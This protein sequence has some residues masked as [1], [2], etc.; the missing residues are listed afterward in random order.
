MSPKSKAYIQ[1]QQHV[2]TTCKAIKPYI[3]KQPILHL[4]FGLPQ[5][6]KSTMLR[7]N[8]FNQIKLDKEQQLISLW[9]HEQQ[10]VIELQMHWL[11]ESLDT[12]IVAPYFNFLLK[13]LSKLGP[14][15]ARIDCILPLHLLFDPK[16]LTATTKIKLLHT[17][18]N[19]SKNHFS[20][21]NNQLIFTHLD[22]LSGFL[23]FFKS[24]PKHLKQRPFNIS[25]TPDASLIEN[26]FWQAQLTNAMNTWQQ[27]LNKIM[28]ANIHREH[29]QQTIAIIHNVPLQWAQLSM[30]LKTL[31]HYF[32]DDNEQLILH[33]LYFTSCYQSGESYDLISNNINQLPILEQARAPKLEQTNYFCHDL[34]LHQTQ[35]TLPTIES[36]RSFK[37]NRPITLGIISSILFSWI[38]AA[39]WLHQLAKPYLTQTNINPSTTNQMHLK[40]SQITSLP[41][42]RMP[43]PLLYALLANK[44]QHTLKQYS[45]QLEQQTQQPLKQTL[46]QT[47]SDTGPTLEAVSTY[48]QLNNQLRQNSNTS[49][50]F[51]QT[52]WQNHAMPQKQ[53]N[54]LSKQL[55]PFLNKAKPKT[56]NLPLPT[57]WPQ[58][59]L[60]WMYA[61]LKWH[62]H[63]PVTDCFSIKP[64]HHWM[65]HTLAQA[66]QHLSENS[67]ETCL[68]Q[69]Q[70]HYSQAYLKDALKQLAPQ[71]LSNHH[72]SFKTILNQLSTFLKQSIDIP[73]EQ[74]RAIRPWL[75][76]N[77]QQDLDSLLNY[78][79]PSSLNEDL[80]ALAQQLSLTKENPNEALTWVNQRF[81]DQSEPLGPVKQHIDSMPKLLSQTWQTYYHQVW[82]TLLTQAYHTLDQAWQNEIYRPFQAVMDKHF[83]LD[84]NAHKEVSLDAFQ[85]YFSSQGRIFSFFKNHLETL[86]DQKETTWH[87]RQIDG[88]NMPLHVETLQFIMKCMVMHYQFFEDDNT[89]GFS[90][91]LNPIA[92][93]EG[94]ASLSI[95]LDNQ[96]YFFPAKHQII[97]EHHWPETAEHSNSSTMTLTL[98]DSQG[99]ETIKTLKGQWQWLRMIN[100]HKVSGLNEAKTVFTVSLRQLALPFE[101]RTEHQPNPF[102]F[103]KTPVTCPPHP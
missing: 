79:L 60:T 46:L 21:S 45:K 75:S 58:G 34:M 18:F 63:E 67:Q 14:K 6:G 101:V 93:P 9:Q 42:F 13:K 62:K 78:Q 68:Q 69:A 102:N 52:I 26:T 94:V 95:Q 88:Q 66:C 55:Q 64:L 90:F 28:L 24:L 35:Q 1:F 15:Q 7:N 39:V 16:Q 97:S 77:Q 91:S 80:T 71:Q 44:D 92:W 3:N 23:S 54:A 103:S 11:H 74:L 25:F 85:A 41:H 8:G 87:W 84:V 49:L 89:L 36:T 10:I 96:T 17:C 47:L 57:S 20:S 86:I 43:M 98:K 4:C 19:E 61:W 99:F 12:T 83:P 27:R 59:Q 65:E 2:I 70:R 48:L 81:S 22:L 30:P 31:L 82:H 37:I 33:H 40:L 100:K 29:D 38:L 56:L 73:H 50:F 5:S 72:P 76:R 32:I 51:L 53:I